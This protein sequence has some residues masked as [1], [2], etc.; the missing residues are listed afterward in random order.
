MVLNQLLV[1][2][3]G[4]LDGYARKMGLVLSSGLSQKVHKDFWR[5]VGLAVSPTLFNQSKATRLP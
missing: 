2:L 1:M 3:D 4:H 5:C